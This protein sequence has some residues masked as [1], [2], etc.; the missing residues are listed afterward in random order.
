MTFEEINALDVSDH[1]EKVTGDGKELSYLSWTWAV[2][3]FK[4]HF[5]DMKY[6]VKLFDNGS[7]VKLPYMFD[8]NTGYMV[9]TSVTADGLTQDMWLPV[10]DAKNKAMKSEPYTYKTKYGEK[11]V[12]SATMFD[13]NKTIMRCLVKNFAM[14]GLGLYIYAGEDVPE[15]EKYK[16]LDYYVEILKT[17]KT[18]DEINE[19]YKVNK[20]LIKPSMMDDVIKA[21]AT[22]KAEINADQSEIA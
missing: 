12:E 22:R 3:E 1:I 21:C 17:F 11:R 18:V 4:K 13:V 19:F 16:P 2:A 15:A 5:P 7:G 6:E 20:P 8:K 10:M 9:S 14:F